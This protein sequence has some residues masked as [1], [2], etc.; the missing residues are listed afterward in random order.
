MGPIRRFYVI[1]N[2]PSKKTVE[3]WPLPLSLFCV[4]MQHLVRI[5][6][7]EREIPFKQERRLCLKMNS[8]KS[9]KVLL[10]NADP[11]SGYGTCIV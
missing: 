10:K 3:P 5:M 6:K 4:F 11:E 9:P 1:R 8:C 2:R 7:E